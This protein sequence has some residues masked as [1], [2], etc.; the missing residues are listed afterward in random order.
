MTKLIIQIPCFN[1]E[2]CLADTLAELP[3]NLVG[4]DTIEWLVI[5]D[6][7]TDNTVKVA[8][9]NGV[10]HVVSLPCNQGLA[11]AFR[12]GIEAGLAQGADIIVNTD[13]DN[14]Y[15][16]GDIGK[17]V[18]PILDGSAEMVVGA[19][20]IGQTE[21]FSAAKKLLQGLGSA[22][23]RRVSNTDIPDAPSGFRAFSRAAAKRINVFSDYTYTLETIIQAGL[24]NM[25][26]TWVPIRTNG[27][28]RPSKLISSIPKY[29]RRS[30][31]TAARIFVTYRPLQFFTFIG[32]MI[33]FAGFAIG[34]RFLFYFL[35]G[36][37]DGH[38]QSLILAGLLM[39]V[40]FQIGITGILADL[41]S[42]NRKLIEKVDWNV[43]SL[44]FEH[45]DY[46]KNAAQGHDR[47]RFSVSNR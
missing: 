17:L 25:A 11:A 40:G 37:G 5:D 30:I 46:D 24:K 3:R 4:I 35:G 23:I 27:P 20:P 16:A 22:F 38:I 21:H 2:E 9:A 41:I 6:G 12:A 36:E 47:G 31:G 33:F 26:I 42:V 18:R 7:S 29:I 34:A 8:K 39:G 10:D 15:H 32:G 1:E 28:T 44:Q 13:A 45:R 19:R 43:Q 14:Q